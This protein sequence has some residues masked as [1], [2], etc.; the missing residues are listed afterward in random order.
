[1]TAPS[2]LDNWS[3][4]S[5]EPV[6]NLAEVVWRYS[7]A[8]LNITVGTDSKT[9]GSLTTMVT[10]LC[11]REVEARNGVIVFY[12]RDIVPR[13]SGLRDQLYEET[14]RSIALAGEVTR[15]TGSPPN[16]HVDI[17]PKQ[18]YKSNRYHDEIMGVVMGCN[19]NPSSKPDAWAADIAD[20]FT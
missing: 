20:M 17:N 13:F 7:R 16:I 10:A 12:K 9:Y 1:M 2:L 6:V 14:M 5:G 4:L 8:G 3:S 11:F 18:D 19:Y 15:L